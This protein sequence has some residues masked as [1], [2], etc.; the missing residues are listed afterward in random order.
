MKIKILV[1]DDDEDIRNLLDEILKIRSFHVAFAS[2]P[3]EM[4]EK[5]QSFKPDLMILDIMLGEINAADWIACHS[6]PEAGRNIPILFLSGLLGADSPSPAKP[7]NRR[8]LRG[9]PFKIE[10]LLRDIDCLLS[11]YR[12]PQAA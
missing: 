8:A 12:H 11:T 5:L 3:A 1:V 4:E 6:L 2:N 7:G 10:E 9:K